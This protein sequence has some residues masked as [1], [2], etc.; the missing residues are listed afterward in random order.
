MSRAVPRRSKS[1]AMIG[2]RKTLRK[3]PTKSIAEEHAEL[4]LRQLAEHDDRA[5]RQ[6]REQ[7]RRAT[8]CR[9]FLLK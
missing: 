9:M 7:Q 8:K 5:D 4:V 3:M 6:Q 2:T 1:E